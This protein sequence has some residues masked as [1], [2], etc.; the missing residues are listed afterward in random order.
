MAMEPPAFWLVRGAMLVGKPGGANDASDG[1]GTIL[2]S[3]ISPFKPPLLRRAGA[4]TRTEDFL[5]FS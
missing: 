5:K 4:K 2:Q 1:P 3:S